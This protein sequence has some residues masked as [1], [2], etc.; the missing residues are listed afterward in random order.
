MV[1]SLFI[2][3]Q[4]AN[5]RWHTIAKLNRSVDGFE[6][7]FTKGA[8]ALGTVPKSLFGLDVGFRYKF[9]ELLPLLRNRLPSKS[10]SDYQRL[11]EWLDVQSPKDQF[12]LLARFGLI[13][14][15][16]SLLI[17]PEPTLHNGTFSVDFFVHGIRHM[18]RDVEEWAKSA[19]PGTAIL[20]MLDLQNEVDPN[21]VALRAR[22]HAILLGYVPAFYANAFSTILSN[23]AEAATAAITLLK[24]NPMAPS[25]IKLWCRFEAK[26]RHQLKDL[27]GA[28]SEPRIHLSQAPTSSVSISDEIKSRASL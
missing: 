23:S 14:G 25:Q 26:T 21:A 24:A 4:D 16:D 22:H 27:M 9:K 15:T 6:F 19:I 13:P 3:W 20:P 11:S 18:H 1:E 8:E 28:D 7:A 5:R 2:A 10:R 17:Y 12:D